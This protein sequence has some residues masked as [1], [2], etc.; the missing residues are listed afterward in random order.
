MVLTENCFSLG[1]VSREAG[2]PSGAAA[3]RG[4]KRKV[5][6]AGPVEDEARQW[7]ELCG[8]TLTSSGGLGA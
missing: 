5:M 1:R 7:G 6:Q 2:Q 8:K 3:A 4:G